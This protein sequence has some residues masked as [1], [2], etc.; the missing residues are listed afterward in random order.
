L[1]P[2]AIAWALAAIGVKQ[3]ANAPIVIAAGVGVIACLIA[4]LSFVMNLP[5]RAIGSTGPPTRE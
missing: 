5:T 1:Y 3:S 4:A 2:L